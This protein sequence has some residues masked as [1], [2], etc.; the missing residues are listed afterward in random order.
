MHGVPRKAP[1]E[2]DQGASS[3]KAAKVCDLQ[4]QVLHFHHNKMG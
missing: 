3:I 4:S 2:E 1:T